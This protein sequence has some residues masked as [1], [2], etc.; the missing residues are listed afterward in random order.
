MDVQLAEAAAE[1]DVLVVGDV[2]VVEEEDEVLEKSAVQRAEGL[3]VER[4]AQIDAVHSAPMWRVS[5]LNSIVSFRILP[6]DGATPRDHTLPRGRDGSS[7]RHR[8]GGGIP[9]RSR[10]I[11]HVHCGTNSSVRTGGVPRGCTAM[12]EWSYA[13][14]ESSMSGPLIRSGDTERACPI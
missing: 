14:L 7:T 5:G 9:S 8:A 13:K 11:A 3:I 1:R 4:L 12:T 10:L 2:L 6:S